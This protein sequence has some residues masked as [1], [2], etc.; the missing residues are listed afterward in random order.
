VAKTVEEA[1][2]STL[3]WEEPMLPA[4]YLE[5]SCGQ[6]HMNKPTEAPKLSA[7]RASLSRYGC[8]H[9][10]T[11]SLPDGTR[12]APT[13]NPPPLT[14]IAD[15]TTREW[16]FAWLKNPQAYSATATMPNFQFSD[17]DARD[18]S[19]FLMAQSTS[20]P[21]PA[22]T[23]ASV[24]SQD[25]NAL[26]AGASAYGESFCASCHAIQ[27]AAGLLVGGNLGPELTRIGTKARPAW[28]R[29]WVSDPKT[30]DPQTLMPHYR[31]D[32]KR[33]SLIAGFLESKTDPDFLGN[34]HLD[35]ATP[36][37]VAHG[38]VLVTENGC[39]SCHDINGIR[40]PESF[41]PDLTTVGSRPLAKI[42]FLDGM[43]HTLP[44]YIEAKIK[45]PRSFGPALKMP[46]FNLSV[47]Q[48][49]GLVTALLAQTDRAI[50]LPARLRVEGQLP[51]AYE[52][53][54]AAG[55][56][57]HDMNCF[58]CHSINGRGGDMAP[59]LTWEGS[60][61]QRE[62]LL[63]FFKNPNTLRPTLIRRMPKFNVSDQ[64]A[65]VL[66]DYILAVYQSP[67]FDRDTGS[68]ADSAEIE[69]GRQLFYSKY[70]CQACHIVDAKN[71]KGYIGPT[72]TQVG[73]RLNASWI[74]EWLKA[75]Q[76]LRPGTLEP[77]RQMS[78]SDASAL[79]A[80]L[81]I[82]K[83]QLSNTEGKRK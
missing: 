64:E 74:F 42:A 22:T 76:K 69:R 77:D 28:L 20:L 36:Q 37:Q 75:P 65:A 11:L 34:V 68:K 1:H 44:A 31:F 49:D 23:A 83:G 70:A 3:A 21:E 57:M 67:A 73:S 78:D 41:A 39:A 63:A 29:Q 4:R 81:M 7:G 60:A 82:Q 50:G 24:S 62:W 6:C 56:L 61:V 52:P 32:D 5:S 79:T 10:H 19:A 40:K 66:T 12:I 51:S 30:Y 25:A 48:V 35:A 17:D 15:K 16:A 71:D 9:C 58:S 27:N 55:R 47:P 8:V 54:G 43:E 80:F 59:D 2:R 45:Q 33:L 13:D 46:Q 18:I 26:Q 38:K 53:A 14:H 72:L